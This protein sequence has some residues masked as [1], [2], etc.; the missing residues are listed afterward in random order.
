MVDPAD[1]LLLHEIHA[2]YGVTSKRPSRREGETGAGHD[3]PADHGR[4]ESPAEKKARKIGA[5][6]ERQVRHPATEVPEASCP[7]RSRD[8]LEIFH[9]TLNEIKA[10]KRVPVGFH[11][12]GRFET[13]ETFSTGRM[14]KGL[15][16][17]LEYQIWYPRVLL[18]CQALELL[19]TF[20]IV[21]QNE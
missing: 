10:R 1:N 20:P 15:T 19:K 9:D 16:V 12:E 14:R 6:Q 11:L 3:D 18:W 4:K 17:T 5:G 8:E 21:V 13:S 7:F 2:Y